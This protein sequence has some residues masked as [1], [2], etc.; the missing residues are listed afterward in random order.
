MS[1]LSVAPTLVQE[2]WRPTLQR[3]LRGR[4]PPRAATD[5][6]VAAA[7]VLV[8]ILVPM[9]GVASKVTLAAPPTPVMVE[10]MREGELP[11]SSG[12]GPHD[13]S[14][15][16]KPKAPEGSVARMELGCAAVSR[17]NEVVDIPSDDEADA[18]AK[19]RELEVSP[20]ELAVSPR[21]LAVVQSEAGPSDISSEGDLE[22]AF[23]EDPSKARFILRDS[24]EHQL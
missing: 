8:A 22:W 17:G 10:E 9:A 19:P 23:L 1:G 13:L 3:S 7:S 5:K 11:I 12:G 2:T 14:L 4:V 20:W 15:P 6:A 24:R 16:S 18:M 21:E